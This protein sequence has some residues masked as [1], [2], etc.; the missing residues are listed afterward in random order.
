MERPVRREPV[1]HR[2]QHGQLKTGTQVVPWF[3]PFLVEAI[4]PA[5]EARLVGL[6]HA[7]TAGS[8]LPESAGR[9]TAPWPSETRRPRKIGPDETAIAT[10]VGAAAGCALPV[11]GVVTATGFAVHLAVFSANRALEQQR[12]A[13]ARV[14]QPG[15][16]ASATT[17]GRPHFA[18]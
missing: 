7:V 10:T 11:L 4:D 12:V 14:L 1:R 2:H 13:I 17:P 15:R 18:S 9:S 5:Q 8:Y 16:Q 6:D 3:F